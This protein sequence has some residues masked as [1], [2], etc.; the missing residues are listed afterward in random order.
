M[1]QRDVF[2]YAA[3]RLLNNRKDAPQQRNLS[4]QAI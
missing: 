1:P 4:A 2:R 3:S